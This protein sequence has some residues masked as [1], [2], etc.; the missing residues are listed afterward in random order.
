MRAT[1]SRPRDEAFARH[2]D[3][4]AQRGFGGALAA[5]RLQ[6]PELA[7]LDGEFHVLH[8]AV[9]ALERLRHAHE[10]GENLG[11][12]RLH[13]RLVGMRGDAAPPR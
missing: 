1:A 4:D 11:Q 5:A 3:G 6:H 10:F 2:V 8:V 13:R 7:A 9:M 12:Q